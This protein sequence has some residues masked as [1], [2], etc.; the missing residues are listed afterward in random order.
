VVNLLRRRRKVLLGSLLVLVLA[1]AAPF[2]VI[3]IGEWYRDI[4]EAAIFARHLRGALRRVRYQSRLLGRPQQFIVYLPPS[5]RSPAGRSRRYPVIYLLQGCPG[6]PRDWLV[7]GDV[8]DIIEHLIGT[9][10]AQEMILVMADGSGPR[11]RFDCTLY[12][13]QIH[14][15][16]PAET[17][18]VRELVPLV[19]HRFRTAARREGRALLGVSSG[20][21]AALNLG[22]R[23]PEQF[24]VLAS[25]SGYFHAV[26]D[27]RAV[28][29]ILD[30]DFAAWAR[31]SPADHLGRIPRGQS[32]HIYLNVGMTDP[33]RA[34]NE[35]FA[36]E[37]QQLGID[38]KLRVTHGR[39]SWSFWQ[40]NLPSS[41]AW[42]SSHL[43]T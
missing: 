2:V 25:H 23:H 16:Y 11:G 20:G 39:H 13:D 41:L 4:Q 26:D 27:P 43:S 38:Y 14:G 42:V 18:F 32:P 1:A 35:A 3:Q 6:Q 19:D 12:M 36:R 9:H 34:E 29:A 15:A 17:A 7:K 37:L 22:V 21:F 31:N 28:R 30:N 5:Y 40:R 33:M 10:A 24:S 8:H